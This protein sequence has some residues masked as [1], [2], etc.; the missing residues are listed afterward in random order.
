VRGEVSRPFVIQAGPLLGGGQTFQS[1]LKPGP[2]ACEANQVN[3][4]RYSCAWRAAPTS[5]PPGAPP[6][7]A[8]QC[9]SLR[10]FIRL[11]IASPRATPVSRRH[12]AIRQDRR[13]PLGATIPATQK[14]APVIHYF[15][16]HLVQLTFSKFPNAFRHRF[17]LPSPWRLR[18]IIFAA[19]RCKGWEATASGPPLLT[20][21]VIIDRIPGES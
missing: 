16:V 7:P 19:G 20:G 3:I 6:A 4:L 12:T 15:H 18:P 11:P 14:R 1:I 21:D 9:P 13:D 8:P 10:I 2:G 17:S 5:G